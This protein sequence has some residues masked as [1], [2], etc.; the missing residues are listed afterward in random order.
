MT[1]KRQRRG[2]QL[3]LQVA[4]AALNEQTILRQRASEYPFHPSQWIQWKQPRSTGCAWCCVAQDQALDRKE[5]ADH[6]RASIATMRTEQRPCRV[7]HGRERRL[8]DH[9]TL[10]DLYPRYLFTLY[11][12]TYAFVRPNIR[13]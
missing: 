7:S 12:M 2:A 4:L 10:A 3:R 6:L 8:V 5:P 11:S 9:P 1:N 13:A